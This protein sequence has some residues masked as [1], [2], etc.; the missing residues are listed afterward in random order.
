MFYV[1]YLKQKASRIS[2]RQLLKAIKYKIK[3]K[4]KA[5]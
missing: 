2:T 1:R 5:A 4:L 3:A